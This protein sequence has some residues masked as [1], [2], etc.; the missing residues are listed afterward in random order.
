MKIEVELR[1][2]NELQSGISRMTGKPWKAR[3]II[4]AWQEHHYDGTEGKIQEQL[5][6][7]RL[8]NE[9]V[10]KFDALKL[11]PGSWFKVDV[12]FSTKAFGNSVG[13]E[14]ELHNCES[15]QM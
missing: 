10:E 5:V 2:V 1:V 13:N 12:I 14:V 3:N 8:F 15:I 9:E 7:G 11:V 4:I 6:S